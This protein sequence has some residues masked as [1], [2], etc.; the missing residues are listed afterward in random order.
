MSV[1]SPVTSWLV[2]VFGASVRPASMNAVRAA[3]TAAGARTGPDRQLGAGP[4]HAVAVDVDLP[5]PADR[6]RSD[7]AEVTAGLP[8]DVAVVPRSM[9]GPGPRVVVTDVDSTFIRGEVIEMLAAHAG[10]EA[11]VRAVTEAAM[12]GELDFAASLHQRVRALAG[13]DVR[14]LDEVRDGLELTP[15]AVE[16]CVAAPRLGYEV[17]LVSGGFAEI[18][19]PVATRLGIRRVRANRLETADGRLTG[20]VLGPVVGRSAKAEALREFAAEDGVPLARTVAVGDG[21]NDLE[22]LAT[23]GLGIAFLAKPVVQA[24]ADAVINLPRLDAVLTL[25]GYTRAQIEADLAGQRST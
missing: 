6:L 14:V 15:G 21:A 9:T 24:Q 16:L 8:E 7:L 4:V 1:S 19:E 20:R 13:L 22:M 3:L 12:R 10:R 2:T 17:A 5:G 18:I 11:E 23:A 25:L